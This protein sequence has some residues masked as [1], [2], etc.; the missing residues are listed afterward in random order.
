MMVHYSLVW[1]CGEI[2]IK[3]A[4]GSQKLWGE[5]VLVLES[6]TLDHNLSF[7]QKGQPDHRTVDSGS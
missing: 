6:F 7:L 3:Q 5:E 1:E 4:G 2:E